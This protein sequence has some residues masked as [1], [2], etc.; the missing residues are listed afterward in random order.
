[1]YF[2]RKICRIDLNRDDVTQPILIRIQTGEA[3]YLSLAYD[4][5]LNLLFWFSYARKLILASDLSLTEEQARSLETDICWR[6]SSSQKGFVYDT[7]SVLQIILLAFTIYV[8]IEY[9]F[10]RFQPRCFCPCGTIP[11]S[12]RK[13]SYIDQQ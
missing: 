7:F 5:H 2:A 9:C 6:S 11:Q 8:F 12:G 10:I 1:M 13:P 4:I 3:F